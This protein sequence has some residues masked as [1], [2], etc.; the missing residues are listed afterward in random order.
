[1]SG[2]IAFSERRLGDALEISV[3]VDGRFAAVITHPC[4]GAG[5]FLR[6][7]FV[8]KKRFR[9]RVAAEAAATALAVQQEDCR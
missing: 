7:L 3:E 9:S 5:W 1:M 4:S 6:S 2:K 8:N